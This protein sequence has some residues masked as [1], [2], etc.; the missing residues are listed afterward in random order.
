MRRKKEGKTNEYIHTEQTKT[1]HRNGDETQYQLYLTA[2]VVHEARE[3]GINLS[4]TL[5]AVLT[6]LVWQ[7]KQQKWKEESREAIQALNDWERE[8]GPFTDDEFY[9]VL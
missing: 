2:Q 8:T 7:K 4:A 6:D 5:D 1:G 3:P 9:G